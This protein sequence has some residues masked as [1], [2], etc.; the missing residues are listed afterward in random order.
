MIKPLQDKFGRVHTNLRISVTDRCNIRC[1]Y[2]MPEFVQ[3]KPREEILTFEE[4]VRFTGIVAEA[5]VDKLRLTGGEPL[6][7]AGLPE[8]IRQLYRVPGIRDI[9]MT[10]NGI[11]LDQHAASLREAGL[12]RLNVSLDTLSEDVFERISRRTGLERVLNGITTAKEVGFD[13]IRLNAIAIKDLTEAEILPLVRFAGEHEM[14]L[15]FIEFMPLDADENW[16]LE[17]V[18]TGAELRSMIES[19][20]GE[21]HTADRNDASQ[22]AIDFTLQTG[23]R[24]GFIN[25]VSEPFCGNCNRL[26][27]TAEGGIRN[28]LFS[29]A[30]WNV[31]SLLRSGSEQQVLELVRTSLGEKKRGHGKDDLDFLRPSKA[32]Y[33]IGG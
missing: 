25:S 16:T 22:P 18:L 5:G 3:F 9:A 19:E 23:Q 27:L 33:Q 28:C 14:E 8:L 29:D 7:R 2:C 10:T 11:L 4:I 6:L 31:R 15:R 30:E 13:Q 1:F 32:M 26:R 12:H 17:E 24:I 20:F 21:L